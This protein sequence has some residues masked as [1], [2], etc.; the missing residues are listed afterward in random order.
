MAINIRAELAKIEAVVSKINSVGVTLQTE[1]HISSMLKASHTVMASGFISH[2]TIE[3]IK[4][5]QKF[6]HMYE[7][8]QIG[9]PNARLWKHVLRGGGK[10]RKTF[11]EFKASRKTVP[12][13]KE[14]QAVG[15]KQRHIFYW[16]APVLEYGLPVRIS[17]KTAKAL[18]Y[19]NKNAKTNPNA[20]FVGW[21]SGGIVYRE[22]PV[23]IDKQGNK[24]TWGSFTKEYISWF[25]SDRPKKLIQNSI[26]KPASQTVKNVL[27]SE[28][29]QVNRRKF[30]QKTLSIEA[31]A[32][33]PTIGA[34][35]QEALNKNY[36]IA[37]RNRMVEE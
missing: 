17:R 20:K 15:V 7:W 1:A 18:V 33:D 35:L 31:T 37:S 2:M 22:S 9:D 21:E 36:A 13:P 27:E 6:H 29:K 24:M 26:L 32:Y 34:K 12:V 25:S 10:N 30:R 11:F 23:S 16:K 4:N 8:N 28:L 5:P 3:S 19:L 14:L